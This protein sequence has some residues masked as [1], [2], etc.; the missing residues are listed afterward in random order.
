MSTGF[1]MSVWLL[2]NATIALTF[3]LFTVAILRRVLR[4]VFAPT[5]IYACWALLPP[6]QRLPFNN[7]NGEQKQRTQPKDGRP[8]CKRPACKP[9]AQGK[10]C[11]CNGYSW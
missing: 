10:P 3:A 6:W 1:S 5:G 7:G 9:C 4:P 11:N 8:T 2:T